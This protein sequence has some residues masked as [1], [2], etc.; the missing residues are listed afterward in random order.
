MRIGIVR[1][2]SNSDTVTA[3]SVA[4]QVIK[5][6]PELARQYST[7]DLTALSSLQEKAVGLSAGRVDAHELHDTLTRKLSGSL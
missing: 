6:N 3:E 2:D 1:G 7:G 4:T 5:E